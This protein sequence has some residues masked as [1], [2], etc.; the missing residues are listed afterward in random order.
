MTGS[1]L[2]LVC[3]AC[4][5]CRVVHRPASSEDIQPTERLRPSAHSQWFD[6]RSACVR[7]SSPGQD[8]NPPIHIVVDPRLG[9]PRMQSM[10]PSC[11]LHDGAPPRDRH[12]QEQG[13]QC[14]RRR[15]S[16]PIGGAIDCHPGRPSEVATGGRN[17]WFGALATGT[18]SGSDSRCCIRPATALGV[19]FSWPSCGR[20][21]G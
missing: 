2:L 4:H 7:T 15:E 18:E 1:S 14:Q 21:C 3:F 10:Q 8:R 13:V 11:V 6:S 12:G 19:R 17:E 20:D 16:R 5:G 9:L